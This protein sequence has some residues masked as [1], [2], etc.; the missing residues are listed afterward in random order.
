MAI[1]SCLAKVMFLQVIFP[2]RCDQQSLLAN[3]R[4]VSKACI[5]RLT[6]LA[7][8]SAFRG[9]ATDLAGLDSQQAH[10]QQG[11]GN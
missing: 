9:S 11:E 6:E 3:E 5:K 7:A 10:E 8:C 1:V 4:A 2:E